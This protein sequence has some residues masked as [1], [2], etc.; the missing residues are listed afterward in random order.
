MVSEGNLVYLDHSATTP[1]CAEVKQSMAD[2][3]EVAWAN[4][5]SMHRAGQQAR[6][7]VDRARDQISAVLG[8]RAGELIFTSGGTEADNLAIRGVVARHGAERGRHV[9][10]SSIEHEAVLATCRELA[11]NGL[12]DLTVVDCDRCGVVDPRDVASAV[13]DDTVLV[14]I[15]YVNNETGVINDITTIALAVKEKNP[16]TFVH[17][18]AVQALGRVDVRLENLGVDLMS[19]SGHKVYGPKGIGA[20]WHK[21]DVALRGQMSGGGQERGLR[22]GTENVLG[23]VGFGVAAERA[24]T[25]RESEMA[26]QGKLAAYLRERLTETIPEVWLANPELTVANIVTASIPD[27]PTEITVTSLDREGIC[28]SGGSACSSGATEPSH[29]LK[30]MGVEPRYRNG[31]VRMSLGEQTTE[32]DIDRVVTALA[33]LRGQSR[34]F[35]GKPT[36]Q[37]RTA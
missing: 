8:C 1:L 15:M 4:P 29:V 26:R 18:D 9:V 33:T 21:R 36:T 23:I 32:L 30:A 16:R 20:L 25:R 10:T 27:V 31:P 12:I 14:S 13:R 2:A 24:S 6:R 37:V 3:M 5:S 28:V 7:A 19:L 22:S 34:E 17:T 35:V 11:Q